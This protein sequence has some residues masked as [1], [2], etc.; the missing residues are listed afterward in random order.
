MNDT[1]N[2]HFDGIL[3]K[4]SGSL[5]SLACGIFYQI[6]GIVASRIMTTRGSFSAIQV[7]I[8]AMQN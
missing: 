6:F 2:I 1:A 7:D 3:R 5:V 8:R 4:R